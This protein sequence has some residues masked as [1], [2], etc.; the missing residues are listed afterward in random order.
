MHVSLKHKMNAEL[1][2][3]KKKETM[4]ENNKIILTATK[5]IINL[6]D[7]TIITII[8]TIWNHG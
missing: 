7:K 8:K 3:D 1:T 5:V 2:M 4:T 6:H